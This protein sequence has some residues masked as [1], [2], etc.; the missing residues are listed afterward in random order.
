MKNRLFA[1]VVSDLRQRACAFDIYCAVVVK[2]SEHDAV[3]AVCEKCAR[4]VHGDLK[5]RVSIA[6]AAFAR[7]YHGHYFYAGFLFCCYERA[8]RWS[9]TAMEKAAVELHTVR[10]GLVRFNYVVGACTADL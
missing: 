6:E 7:P 9:Q 2:E 1:R 4:V 3:C 10:A 5:L 8:N